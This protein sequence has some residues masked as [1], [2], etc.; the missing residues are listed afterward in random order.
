MKGGHVF[1]GQT[2]HVDPL[3]ELLLME[4]WLLVRNTL[5]FGFD[6]YRNLLKQ[7]DVQNTLGEP[8][9]KA[10]K[11]PKFEQNRKMIPSCYLWYPGPVSE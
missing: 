3:C 9:K 2:V 11:R 4:R 1:L 7:A 6:V 5:E 10:I 8:M